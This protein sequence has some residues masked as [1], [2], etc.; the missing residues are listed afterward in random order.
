MTP[1]GEAHLVSTP[2]APAELLDAL[3]RPES[4]PVP[5]AAHAGDTQVGFLQTHLS[6]L[7]FVGQ[8]VYK[9]KRP[10][11]LGF[12]DFTSPEA[13]RFA[14]D[15]ELRLNAPLGGDTY[16]RVVPIT[17]EHDG[18]LQ[19]DGKGHTV[20]W[21][22]EMDRLP[23]ERMF[24]RLLERGE[25]DNAL[26]ETLAQRL[27][28]FHAGAPT[29]AGVDEHGTPT[30]VSQLLLGNLAELAP[31]VGDEQHPAPRGVAAL[32][33]GLHSFLGEA[34]GASLRTHAELMH[35]RVTEGRIRD[36][37]GDLHAG[38]ICVTAD[39]LVIYDAL[40]FSQHLRCGDVAADLAFLAMDLDARGYRGFS[41]Y[42]VRRYALLAGDPE[43]PGLIDLYKTHRALVRSK[44]ACLRAVDPMPLNQDSGADDDERAAARLEAS[45]YA[46]LAATYLMPPALIVMCGLPGSGKSWLARRLAH[47]F[48]ALVLRSDVLRKRLAGLSP[49]DDG[50]AD[51]GA[52]LYDAA[53][54]DHTYQCM[55]DEAI[56]A[57]EH[58][59]TVVAD[60]T[61]SAARHRARFL[62]A[63]VRL[64]HPVVLVHVQCPDDVIRERLARR[65]QARRD[66]LAGGA[67]RAE[68]SDAGLAV[69]ENALTTFETPDEV[70]P[71]LTVTSS[72]E[73]PHDIVTARVLDQLVRQPARDP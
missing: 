36:G 57:L 34:L 15:E 6:W 71:D 68:A 38:N 1:S 23:A 22:V 53:S 33:P 55:L 54:T 29:G 27:T 64:E 45:N 21:A 62:D 48:E 39:G 5:G 4:Y 63:A 12:V 50:Q 19:V 43:L 58:G 26:M 47:P 2:P 41:R 3:K 51:P 61:F 16:R 31:F 60:A 28:A 49:S 66:A 14:C 44:V 17:R 25:V 42:L 52:G 65:E 73:D 59:R 32:S 8:R 9:V 40:E 70:H 46:Q 69:Y 67:P 10:V 72:G 18:R 20:E 7:F 11:S 56:A 35:R 13:R 24:A 37:H 30:A